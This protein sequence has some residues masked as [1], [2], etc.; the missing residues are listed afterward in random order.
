M[1]VP[2]VWRM[3][4]NFETDASHAFTPPPFDA[5]VDGTLDDNRVHRLLDH[6]ALFEPNR[7]ARIARGTVD[8]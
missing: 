5:V 2:H 4:R 1:N 6:P 7:R 3:N 8:P